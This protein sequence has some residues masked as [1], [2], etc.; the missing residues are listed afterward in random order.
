MNTM[1]ALITREDIEEI[2]NKNSKKVFK[3][4]PLKMGKFSVEDEGKFL[5]HIQFDESFI[6]KFSSSEFKTFQ[7]NLYTD[8]KRYFDKAGI[9][10]KS[11]CHG[12]GCG[13]CTSQIEL[14]FKI[15]YEEISN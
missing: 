11:V 9:R 1:T 2:I 5:I 14:P 6:P 4:T 12:G 15:Q 13:G 3:S 10:C 8:I 7:R